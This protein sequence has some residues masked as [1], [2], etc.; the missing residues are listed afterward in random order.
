MMTMII[1]MITRAVKW[2]IHGDSKTRG[3]FPPPY[4]IAMQICVRLPPDIKLP[5]RYSAVVVAALR[6]YLRARPAARPKRPRKDV[7]YSKEVVHG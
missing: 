1:M 5:R 6:S 3:P 4:T 7:A 2:N